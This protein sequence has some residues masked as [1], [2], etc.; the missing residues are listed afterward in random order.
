[1]FVPDADARTSLGSG[2]VIYARAPRGPAFSIRFPPYYECGGRIGGRGV[3]GRSGIDEAEANPEN[4]ARAVLDETIGGAPSSPSIDGGRGGRGPR[5]SV[6]VTWVMTA[7]Y[8][9]VL[10]GRAEGDIDMLTLVAPGYPLNV[11][12]QG[13]RGGDGGRGTRGTSDGGRGGTGGKGGRGG[14]GGVVDVVLDERFA[15][16]E[17]YVN[18]DV[19]GGEG[20][21][22][23]NGGPGGD[24]EI[25]KTRRHKGRDEQYVQV[26]TSGP[27][28]VAGVMGQR[29]EE[30]SFRVHAGS[31]REKF[32]GVAG[33]KVL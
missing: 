23:G 16:L 31:V 27:P 17:G 28:G 24:R 12:A 30:G 3:A 15:D 29:G 21:A 20:G 26:G 32:E 9:K 33:L 22:A 13:G 25:V 14:D 19:R 8:T 11:I 18:V 10:A 7:D 4:P 5:L 2:F 6:F 1:M